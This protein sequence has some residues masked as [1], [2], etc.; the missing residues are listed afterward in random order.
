MKNSI[1]YSIGA[2]ALALTMLAVPFMTFADTLTR[3]LETGSRGADVSSLQSFL[4]GDSTIYPQGLVTGY[5]GFLTKAAVSNFQTRNGIDSVGRVGPQ[6]LPVINL[7]M[8][9]GGINGGTTVSA[10]APAITSVTTNASRNSA[11][12][13][14][15]TNEAAKGV[16]FYST[17]PLSL[18]ERTNSADVSGSSVMTDTNLRTSQAVSVQNLSSNTVYYYLIYTTDENGNVS[19]TWPSTFQTSI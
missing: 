14:W 6:T 3:Q 5:F 11:M 10:Q 7:Q 12:V 18:Y 8:A 4:A 1:G 2:G 9:N 16:V 13:S 17:S 15:N 19:M